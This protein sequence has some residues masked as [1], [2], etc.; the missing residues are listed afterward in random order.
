MKLPRVLAAL[1]TLT[2]CHGS[3]TTTAVDGGATPADGGPGDTGAT[4]PH[5]ATI[6]QPDAR[7]SDAGPPPSV[8]VDVLTQHNDIARTG[9]NASETILTPG[10]VSAATFGKLFTV[11]VDG[12]ISAQ[13]LVV[14]SY[15]IGGQTRNAVFVTT[16]HDSVYA[17]DADTAEALWHVSLGTPLPSTQVGPVD[18]AVGTFNVLPELGIL[19]TPVIDR[20]NDLLYVTSTNYHGAGV[21]QWNRAPRARARH[22]RGDER[23]PGRHRGERPRH[24]RRHEHRHVRGEHGDAEARAPPAGRDGLP[25]VRLARRLPPVPRLRPRVP[26]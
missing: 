2:A 24:G 19:S 9:V 4:T 10:T 16:A 22:G 7:R 21:P 1:A 20:A 17:F 25:R 3:A 8:P 23:E 6:A 14:S 13:P 26:L 11:P 18:A 15:A 5:D 12:L